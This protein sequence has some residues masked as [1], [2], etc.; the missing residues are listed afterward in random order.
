MI[1]YNMHG[2]IPSSI[3]CSRA[4]AP[5]IELRSSKAYRFKVFCQAVY[6]NRRLLCLGRSDIFCN[7]N[8]LLCLDNDATVGLEAHGLA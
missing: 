3:S 2:K 7:E 8:S 5:M 4:L 6:D 1:S